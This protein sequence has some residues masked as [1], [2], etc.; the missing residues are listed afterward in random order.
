MAADHRAERERPATIVVIALVCLAACA[1]GCGFF[2][3]RPD[4]IVIT[5]DTL[6]AD[7]IGAYGC[8]NCS[9]PTMDALAASGL[10]FDEAV[11]PLPRTTPA[12][13]SMLTGLEPHN[14]RSREVGR[15]IA[16]V[17]S[18]AGLLTGHGY[19]TIGV[20]ANPSA[21]EVQ[22][23]GRGF[24]A[25]VPPIDLG[26]PVAESVTTAALE[27]VREGPTDQPLFLWL[28]Y[29]DPHQPYAPPP[30]WQPQPAAP[31][32]RSLWDAVATGRLSEGELF[33][34]AD[35]RSSAALDECRM[36][37]DVEISYVDHWI[38]RLLEGLDEAG[39]LD[40]ALV[41]LTSDHG[42]NLGEDGLYYEHGPSLHEASLRVPLIVSG[43]RVAT[44]V[45]GEIARLQDL[46]PTILASAGLAATAHPPMDGVDLGPR[47]RRPIAAPDSDGEIAFSEGASHL[48]AGL[49]TH[50]TSGR[51]DA[52]HCVHD[53]VYAL[54]GRPFQRF[55]F[56]DTVADRQLTAPIEKPPEGV[57]MRLERARQ[58]WPVEE[59]RERSARTAHHKL[60][61]TPRL[62]GGYD[63]ALY[64]LDLDPDQRRDV[65][66]AHPAVARRLGEALDAWSRALP[67]PRPAPARS[68]EELEALRAL[69]YVD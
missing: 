4:I 5:V 45:D 46:A 58:I 61:L 67:A 69:G 9:T 37:Y 12:V 59:A 64:D 39:R 57:R 19:R 25:F 26:L 29:V 11:T 48:F 6:R 38:G 3:N 56:F 10:R 27:L 53:G 65:A 2:D 17:P 41:I 20:S 21:S 32:C 55:R 23:V 22:G 13:G 33:V 63:S 40:D 14:H 1:T 28:L 36:L 54:C 47:L 51:A 8:A 31:R 50:I 52:H 60:L 7:R 66:A 16:E 24:E 42:E 15:P 68:A 30:S 49:T 34:D 35:G 43:P 44:G 18:V 62:D